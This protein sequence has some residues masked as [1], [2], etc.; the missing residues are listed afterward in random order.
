MVSYEYSVCGGDTKAATDKMWMNA[1]GYILIQFHL[2]TLHDYVARNAYAW[3]IYQP[4][5]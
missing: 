1:W 3:H 2:K 4:S 5:Q